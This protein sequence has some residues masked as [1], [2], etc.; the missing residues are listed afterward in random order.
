[1]NFFSINLNSI[2]MSA[3]LGI[4]P[5][6]CKSLQI[7]VREGSRGDV[8]ALTFTPVREGF[9]YRSKTIGFPDV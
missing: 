8:L 3:S 1:M 7:D 4:D 9:S 2:F 6:S 5:I